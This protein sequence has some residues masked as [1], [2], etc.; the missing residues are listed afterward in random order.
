[1]DY[2][3]WQEGTGSKTETKYLQIFCMS[4]MSNI[5]YVNIKM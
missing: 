4:I 2:F 1:M 5:Y 3:G